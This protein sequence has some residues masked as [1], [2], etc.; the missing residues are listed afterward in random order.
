MT[1]GWQT[2]GWAG[3]D[4]VRWEPGWLLLVGLFGV[5]LATSI[6]P[7]RLP[8][9]GPALQAATVLG[10]LAGAIGAFLIHEAAH[11]AIARRYGVSTS[12]V[13]MTLFGGVPEFKR[14]LPN[15]EAMFMVATA[16]PSANLAV[17]VA[18]YVL[19]FG[20]AT[21]FAIVLDLIARVNLLLALIN[22]LPAQPL[23]GG[24]MLHAAM[25][26]ASGDA[27]RAF[28]AEHRSGRILGSV[29]VVAG[30]TLLVLGAWAAG[31]FAASLGL[32]LRSAAHARWLYATG[33]LKLAG[34]P[35]SDYVHA[36]RATLQ[37]AASVESVIPQVE[38]MERR[39]RLPVVDGNRLLGWIDRAR[40]RRL[41]Q[42]DWAHETVG[43]LAVARSDDNTI[44]AT[45]DA[46]EALR[47]MLREG[48]PTLFV[49]DGENLAGV[50]SLESLLAP[51][52]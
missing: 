13:T 7:A 35:V 25:W 5:L 22:L 38:R 39:S 41:P 30:M 50:L 32:L 27:A 26:R 23:D 12:H 49:I 10:A 46:R 28:R 29:A 20:V 19:A 44:D 1:L 40:L 18:A 52:R 4:R 6:L 17:C 51:G 33:E 34:K 14:P 48:T 42:S 3:I 9:A 47:R 31:L 15:P 37:R 24:R 8:E 11:A 21:P 16:G 2:R 45:S 36:P 43:S